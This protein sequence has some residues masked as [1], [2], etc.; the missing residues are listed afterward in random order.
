MVG[1]SSGGAGPEGTQEDI[2]VSLAWS[3]QSFGRK[4]NA[5]T[6]VGT[7][8]DEREGRIVVKAQDAFFSLL[9]SG[10]E[11]RKHGVGIQCVKH[12]ARCG[13]L[14]LQQPLRFLAR[15]ERRKVRLNETKDLA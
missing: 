8:L 14:D 11:S 10:I 5:Q 15:G 13:H 1:M 3:Q 4:L 6:L 7:V 9:T 2:V 12:A